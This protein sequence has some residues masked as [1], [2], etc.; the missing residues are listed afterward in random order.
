MP[1][2]DALTQYKAQYLLF[3]NGILDTTYQNPLL[4][5]SSQSHITTDSQSA[6]PSWC[7]AI[8]SSLNKLYGAEH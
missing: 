4:D 6:S 3:S 1:Q 2:Q 8:G 7:Q 5:L